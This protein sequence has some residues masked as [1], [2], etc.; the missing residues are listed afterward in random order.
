LLLGFSFTRS[1]KRSQMLQGLLAMLL[2]AVS[3]VVSGCGTLQVNG[4]PA[5]TYTFNVTAIGHTTAATQSAPMTLT[6]TQ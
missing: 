6:V 3:V 4:T 2:F 1:R 5:G